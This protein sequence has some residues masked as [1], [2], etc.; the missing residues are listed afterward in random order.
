MVES[1]CYPLERALDAYRTVHAITR[2]RVTL[3][4]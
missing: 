2:N 1:A 3:L 4:P